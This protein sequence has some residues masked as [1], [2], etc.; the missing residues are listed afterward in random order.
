VLDFGAHLYT[1]FVFPEP[2]KQSPLAELLGSLLY[3][4]A[5]LKAR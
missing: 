3:D 4:P 1:E 2:I 5:D